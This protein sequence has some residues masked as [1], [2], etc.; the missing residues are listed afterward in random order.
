MK[1]RSD[2]QK[3]AREDEHSGGLNIAVVRT[4]WQA[5]K[6]KGSERVRQAVTH[7]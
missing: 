5:R 2:I 1:T 4:E 3:R 6:P 7:Q